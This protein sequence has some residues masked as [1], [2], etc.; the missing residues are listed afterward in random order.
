MGR[1]HVSGMAGAGACREP[2]KRAIWIAANT[3]WNVSNFRRRLIRELIDEGYA[4]TVLSPADGYVARVSA[5]GARHIHLD[6]DVAG[7]NPVSDAALVV[8]LF[9]LFREERPALLLT[10]TPKINIYCA[11]AARRAGIP[12]IANVSGLGS[13]F[14]RGGWLTTLVKF[15]YRVA[16]KHPRKVFF[17]NND[18]CSLFRNEALVSPEKAEVLPGSGVDVD[19][20]RPVD[21][22]HEEPHGSF[23][24]LLAARLLIDKGISEYIE[25]A[26]L[27]RPEFPKAQFRLLGFLDS[28]NP[29]AISEQQV[30]EWEAS[31]SIN[32]LGATD[33]VVAY[34]AA[35]DCV[36]LPSYREGCPRSLLEA[37]SM[38]IPLIASDTAG[39]RDVVKDGVN[40]YLCKPRDAED[41]ARQM[42]RMMVLRREERRQMGRAGRD[43]AI[44]IFDERIVIRR[45]LRA[46]QE[47]LGRC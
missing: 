27:L 17:Q 44:K 45:Y 11:I 31:G 36:V 5:L 24:F 3:T 2:V 22:E 42:R 6:M 32:Y 40:G 33:D 30:S 25:A 38:A 12:V 34:Y 10:Y 19:R 8:R 1:A 9:R 13:G 35:A 28:K 47:V 46:V 21:R 4:V 7:T 18:D 41:L 39:C 14:I 23:A 26:R 20:F 43:L 29:T 37:A 15:L 16:L